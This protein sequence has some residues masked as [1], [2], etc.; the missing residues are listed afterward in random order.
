MKGRCKLNP[1]KAA[2]PS[3]LVWFGLYALNGADS[4]GRRAAGEKKGHAMIAVEDRPE[5]EVHSSIDPELRVER[6]D[7]SFQDLDAERVRIR[8]KVHN[9]GA[10]RSKPAFMT[11]ESAPLGAFVPWQ[12]LA[13]LSVPALEAGEARELTVDVKRPRPTPL[14]GFDRVPPRRILAAVNAPDHPSRPN[15]GL[16]TLLGMMIRPRQNGSNTTVALADAVGNLAP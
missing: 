2:N 9:D 1:V 13:A 5:L 7:I 15:S 11:L 8:V 3:N 4:R 6:T 12:P 16:K 14:G 10:S